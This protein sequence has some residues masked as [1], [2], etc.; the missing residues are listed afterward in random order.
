MAPLPNPFGC[1]TVL[2]RSTLGILHHSP[3]RDMDVSENSGTPKSSI[4]TGFSIINHPFWGTPIFGNIHIYFSGDVK[5]AY[6][7]PSEAAHPQLRRPRP[8]AKKKGPGSRP[9]DGSTKQ[10]EQQQQ[11]QTTTKDI[12]LRFTI[13]I[14][15]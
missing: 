6:G 12:L 5:K 11:Q 2:D 9:V 13:L 7:W 3:I 15:K 4:L 1:T 14:Q 10:A 8:S